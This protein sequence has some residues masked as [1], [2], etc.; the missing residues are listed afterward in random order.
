MTIF[1]IYIDRLN[2]H[3]WVLVGLVLVVTQDKL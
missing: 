1:Q 3:T 2:V